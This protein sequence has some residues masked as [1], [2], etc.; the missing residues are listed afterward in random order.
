M[1]AWCNYMI[2]QGDT[3]GYPIIQ[4]GEVV[5]GPDELYHVNAHRVSQPRAV[6]A[7]TDAPF[8][9]AHGV[10]RA[11][12]KMRN[13]DLG[14]Y[15]CQVRGAESPT[16]H[17]WNNFP[18]VRVLL[19]V[20][21]AVTNVKT[22]RMP[23]H[24]RLLRLLLRHRRVDDDLKVGTPNTLVCILWQMAV[25]EWEDRAYHPVVAQ[26]NNPGETPLRQIR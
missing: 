8:L 4:A 15:P 11:V 19:V 13:F 16:G 12:E 10:H 14:G 25:Q 18:F 1:K 3:K 17:L 7:H 21:H 26:K 9:R 6:S 23:D 20:H 5:P 22:L 24:V 2:Q